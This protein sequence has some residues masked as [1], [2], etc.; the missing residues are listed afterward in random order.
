MEDVFFLGVLH[1]A[2]D[3]EIHGVSKRF[4]YPLQKVNVLN[5]RMLCLKKAI[6]LFPGHSN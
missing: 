2:L 1:N 4:Q 5:L 3:L 6:M